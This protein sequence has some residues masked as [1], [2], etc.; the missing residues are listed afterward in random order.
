[1]LLQ[2]LSRV[3]GRISKWKENAA[4]TT[5]AA[6][7]TEVNYCVEYPDE[8]EED[9]EQKGEYNTMTKTIKIEGMMCMHCVKAATKALE[10]V[11]GVSAVNVSLEEKQ[12]VVECADSVTDAALTAA[13]VEEGFKVTEIA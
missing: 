13:I 8:P 9:K 6:K 4:E 7:I 1:M 12:A 3:K 10:A 5:A 11:E 2:A